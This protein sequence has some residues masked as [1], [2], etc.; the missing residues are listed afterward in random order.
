MTWLMEIL[1]IYLEE[2]L[3]V[4]Y[5]KYDGHQRGYASMFYKFYDIKSTLFTDKS[6]SD[7]GVKSKTTIS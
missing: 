3:L 7:S 5:Q 4:K 6:A 2:Q 1:K